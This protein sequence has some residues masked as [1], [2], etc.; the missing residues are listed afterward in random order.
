LLLLDGSNSLLVLIV[1][2]FADQ[3]L[4]TYSLAPIFIFAGPKE[5]RLECE[6]EREKREHISNASWKEKSEKISGSS[7]TKLWIVDINRL[8]HH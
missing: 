4:L 7:F 1:L 5:E 6:L 8:H 3:L 2:S